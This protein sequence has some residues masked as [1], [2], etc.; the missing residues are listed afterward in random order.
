MTDYQQEI[1][2]FVSEI[3]S[4]VPH[5]AHYDIS[6]EVPTLL[7]GKLF[8]YLYLPHTSRQK[9]HTDLQTLH[10]DVDLLRSSKTKVRNRIKGMLGLGEKI[11][12]RDTVVARIDKKVA[13]TFQHEHH[14]QVALPGKYRYGLFH[15]GE[16]VSVAVFSG[17]RRMRQEQENYRSF[18]LLR[19][20]HKADYTVIG[21]ISKLIRRF[22]NEFQPSDIMTYADLDWCQHSTLEKIGFVPLATKPPQ[23]FRIKEDIRTHHDGNIDKEGYLVKNSGSLKLKLIL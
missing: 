13:L 18:E 4:D 22:V 14:L 7:L 21:G 23:I 5:L 2:L 10:I 9:P 16:L 17:G 19:F 8:I 11:Y 6:G 3:S 12:A 1:D 20:C 15:E